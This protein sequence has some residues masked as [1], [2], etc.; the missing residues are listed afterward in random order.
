[1]IL[2]FL[3]IAISQQ[4]SSGDLRFLRPLLILVCCLHLC[5][6]QY[7][8]MQ[9]FAWATMIVDYSAEKG[10]KEGIKDTFDGNHPCELCCSIE[11][12]KK[13]DRNPSKL[14]WSKGLTKLDLT[15]LLP[16]EF[17]VTKKPK[18]DEFIPTG[19]SSPD[20]YIS[21]FRTSPETPPPRIS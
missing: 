19:Y 8:V 11:K 4:Q 14:P 1:L 12:S 10:L 18:W 21:R 2:I 20:S 16:T 3:S 6:G 5:G 7:G 9:M 13:E 17:L 15:N